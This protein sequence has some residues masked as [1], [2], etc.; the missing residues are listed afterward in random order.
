MTQINFDPVQL[1]AFLTC[2]QPLVIHRIEQPPVGEAPAIRARWLENN[3]HVLQ[4]T[5]ISGLSNEPLNRSA[6]VEQAK[7]SDPMHAFLSVMAWGAQNRRHTALGLSDA[8]RVAFSIGRLRAAATVDRIQ[9]YELF[10]GD[11]KIK[12]LGPAYFTKIIAFC[13]ND[14]NGY[15]MDQFTAR[16]INLLDGERREIVPMSKDKNGRLSVHQQALAEHYE[17]YC[18]RVDRLTEVIN[19]R[20]MPATPVDG[21]FTE[22]LL[23]GKGKAKAAWRRHLMAYSNR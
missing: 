11:N 1:Q 8:D 2:V 13:R 20:L 14:L 4:T 7:R 18:A 10:S 16:S 9:A 5:W 17:S 21:F 22:Y 15:V 23:F 3:G 6:L 12:G 19:E